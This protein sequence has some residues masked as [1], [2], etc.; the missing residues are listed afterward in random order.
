MPKKKAILED[1]LTD[2]VASEPRL[3]HAV[4]QKWIRLY[5]EFTKEL[6]EF[7]VNWELM[8]HLPP[9]SDPKLQDKNTLV[10][11]A[12]SIVTDRLYKRRQQRQAEEAKQTVEAEITDLVAEGTLRGLNVHTMADR[13]NLSVPLLMKISRR[14]IVFAGIPKQVIEWISG[15][16]GRTVD[17]VN[18]YLQGPMMIPE[19]V[20]FRAK[21]SP[22]LP[23][24]QEDFFDVVRKDT[25]LD[26]VR[27][28]ALLSLEDRKK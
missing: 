6:T 22:K 5:P 11:R 23:E 2:Y 15:A 18:T 7:T 12:M 17:E 10:L 4:L 1:V 28:A 24:K 19:G 25:T 14:F 27:R 21:S 26:D 8:E 20:K 9:V 13:C 3:S 16:I